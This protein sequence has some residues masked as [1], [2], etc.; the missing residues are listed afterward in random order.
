[1][2]YLDSIISYKFHCQWVKNL[3]MKVEMLK[4]LKEYV[5]KK[6]LDIC[7]GNKFW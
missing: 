4:L 2:K 7:L 1:M 6:L 5:G 3:N